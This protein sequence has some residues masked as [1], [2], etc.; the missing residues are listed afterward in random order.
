MP[1]RLGYVPLSDCAPIAVAQ[2]T[3][4]FKRF[5]LNVNV[6]RELGWGS[7]RDRIFYGELDAAQSIAGVAFA[8]GMG[9]GKLR[10]DVVVPMILNLHGNAITLSN[11]L[12]PS[13]IGK[14]EGLRSYLEKSWK[15]D[16]PFT[17][18]ATHR[19]SSHHILL[20]QWLKRHGLGSAKDVEIIFLPPPS[21]PHHLKSGEIDGYCVSEPWNSEAILAGTGW[22]PVTSADLSQGHPEKVLL[23][24]AKAVSERK[25]ECLTLVA[26]LMESCKLCQDPEFYDEMIAILA[27][28]RYTGASEKVLRNNLGGDFNIGAR[29]VK[30]SSFHIFHG[31]SVNRPTVEKASWVLA[32]LRDIGILPDVTCGSLSRIYREDLFHI[33]TMGLQ[34]A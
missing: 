4:I 2:E 11:E 34:E 9:F 25:D 24:S 1:I 16:R 20:R 32:G 6:S 19:Y 21:M 10:C 5:G 23:M 18:A 27:L 7:I 17:L 28:D 12:K 8:L 3:G 13:F 15:K 22:C 33:A 26:A 31:D 29:T 30:A 14:G